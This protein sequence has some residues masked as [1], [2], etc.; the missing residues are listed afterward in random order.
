MRDGLSRPCVD[1][2]CRT[3]SG[4]L[5]AVVSLGGEFDD[6]EILPPVNKHALREAPR[7]TVYP[8]V[9]KVREYMK[10]TTLEQQDSG[11]LVGY[12]LQ[13]W[14]L[15]IERHFPKGQLGVNNETWEG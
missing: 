11:L 13:D 7:I 4:E 2:A 3:Y 5:G 15:G 10:L 1:L 14:F 9:S 8:F 12:H 6:L